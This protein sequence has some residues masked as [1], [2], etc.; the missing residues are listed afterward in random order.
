[1]KTVTDEIGMPYTTARDY[2]R[3]AQE[4]DGHYE[5]RNGAEDDDQDPVASPA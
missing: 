5:S 2:M 4:A 3:E 1:M